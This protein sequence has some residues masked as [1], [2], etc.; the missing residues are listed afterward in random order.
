MW[1]VQNLQ[2]QKVTENY[3]LKA[4]LTLNVLEELGEFK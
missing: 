4:Q 2:I 1:N 3:R